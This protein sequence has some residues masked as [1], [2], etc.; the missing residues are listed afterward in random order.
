MGGIRVA[1][2]VG[3][4]LLPWPAFA[5]EGGAGFDGAGK[6]LLWA[7]PFVGLLLSIAIMP[8]ALP[9]I[10]HRYFGR[11]TGFWAL[12]FLVPCALN[13][14]IA[15]TAAILA[16][17]L[18]EEY[19]PFLMLLAALF[20]VAG[21]ISLRGGLG[22]TPASNT[23]MLALGAL[24]AGFMGTTGAS[25]L[26]LRP[27][28]R[29]NRERPYKVH[30]FVFFIFLV[31]NIG[32]ALTPLGDPPLFLGFLQ[33]INFTW[34]MFHMAGPMA[35]CGALV[36]AVFYA[37][38]SFHFR[39]N[40]ETGPHLREGF[41]VKGWINVALLGAVLG[42]VVLRGV[43]KS[44]QDIVLLGT[45]L[46]LEGAVLLGLL[47]AI[48]ALSVRFTPM[49]IRVANEFGWAP[50][51]EVAKLFAGIF[52]TIV[53][54]IAILAAGPNGALAGLVETLNPGGVPQPWIYFW[55]TG[56]LSSFLDNAPSWLVL[57]FAAG[58]DPATMMGPL[59]LTLTAISAGAVFM[60]ANSYIG[61]APNFMVKAICEEAGVRMPSFFAY[62][63]WAL[64]V[65][66]PS[67]I[68]VTLVF[69]L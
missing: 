6:S 54:C 69:F 34:F 64:L 40:H 14:G 19:I 7:V 26:L 56:V 24:A 48:T 30:V 58:G 3:L 28:I 27:M 8:L 2:A 13:Q 61:N 37:I 9:H 5:G 23:G 67:F 22:G 32:G 11:I 63:A 4:I 49:D 52:V 53:P 46:P 12:A 45:H 51:I 59:A 1:L 55:V 50:M 25:M 10:W 62:C 21:G 16:H 36:L 33:G 18:I 31:S 39:R 44:G 41:A 43:W 68:V 17:T 65:L 29:A 15:S 38:D 47:A 66:V 60:G 35:L 42:A 57:Y 20:T